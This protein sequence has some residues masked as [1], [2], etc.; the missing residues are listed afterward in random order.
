[1][2]K[3]SD[4]YRPFLGRLTTVWKLLIGVAVLVTLF[5]F[6]ILLGI[7]ADIVKDKGE[8]WLFDT[9]KLVVGE[10]ST[11]SHVNT[12]I[13]ATMKHPALYPMLTF[14]IA[15]L[16]IATVSAL[17]VWWAIEHGAIAVVPE[18]ITPSPASEPQATELP[19]EQKHAIEMAVNRALKQGT[20][21]VG[22]ESNSVTS[23]TTT[24][25]TVIDFG[26]HESKLDLRLQLTLAPS[27][28]SIMVAAPQEAAPRQIPNIVFASFRRAYIFEDMD[29]STHWTIS[30]T[31]GDDTVRALLVVFV[32]EGRVFGQPAVATAKKVRATIHFVDSFGT[33]LEVDPATWIDSYTPIGFDVGQRR[34]LILGYTGLIQFGNAEEECLMSVADRRQPRKYHKY[35][36]SGRLRGKVIATVKLTVD[37]VALKP[38][39]FE[40][41]PPDS[42]RLPPQG[43]RITEP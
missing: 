26:P 27:G 25:A 35:L 20:I 7:V 22:G 41:T 33:T 30:E 6:H 36:E 2:A 15:F 21:T 18:S 16:L 32:N 10:P 37:D 40:I 14:G 4:L 8:G 31:S 1:M 43:R 42:P 29:G 12:L 39:K 23:T 28:G 24:S 3:L 17:Q 34:E 9:S 5:I 13:L 38:E 19:I 11:R